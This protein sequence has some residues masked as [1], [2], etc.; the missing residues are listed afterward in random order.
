VKQVFLL[1]L[2]VLPLACWASCPSGQTKDE[3]ALVQLEQTWAKAL[4]QRDGAAVGCILAAEFEDADPNGALHSRAEA[5]A[6]IPHRRPGSNKLSDLHP[7]VYGDFGYVRGLNTV[8]DPNGKVL[9][10]V[11]F[12]D[13]FVYR[14]GR[15][16]AVA[17]QESLLSDTK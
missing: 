13:I 5:L 16:V 4:E 9:A 7:H 15:W 2:V 12:T 3:A 14:D 6:N 8:V 1:A 11:R 10:R 17:G